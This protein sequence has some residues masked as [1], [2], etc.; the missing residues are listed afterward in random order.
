MSS[1]SFHIPHMGKSPN[2]ST[3]RSSPSQASNTSTATSSTA[4]PT[5]AH[6][7][8]T[9]AST[10][11][12]ISITKLMLQPYP[13]PTPPSTLP[14]T[15]LP[16]LPT[17]MSERGRPARFPSNSPPAGR[18]SSWAPPCPKIAE[19]PSFSRNCKCPSRTGGTGAPARPKRKGCP[20][21]GRTGAPARPKR[22]G[23]ARPAKAP[24][25]RP[26]GNGWITGEMDLIRSPASFP[27]LSLLAFSNWHPGRPF[28][29]PHARRRARAPVLPVLET[30]GKGARPFPAPDI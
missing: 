14:P 30:Q 7:S 2:R 4:R 1:R 18:T 12:G 23:G 19:N 25:S 26:R 20:R 5:L 29:A 17:P 28:C 9:F 24:A 21:T 15:S 16:L 8:R 10:A 27:C 22:K 6:F 13:P 11:S 3:G